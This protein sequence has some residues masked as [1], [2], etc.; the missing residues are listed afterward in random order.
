MTDGMYLCRIAEEGRIEVKVLDQKLT[1]HKNW[2]RE[3]PL[4]DVS[5]PRTAC[6]DEKGLVALLQLDILTGRI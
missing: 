3:V 2:E 1:W 6:M 5:S 4:Q